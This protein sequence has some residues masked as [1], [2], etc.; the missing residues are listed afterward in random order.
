[1]VVGDLLYV[2]G[3][4]QLRGAD[5]KAAWSDT[6]EVLDLS[7]TNP[8][9]RSIPPPFQRRALAAAAAGGK[10]YALGGLDSVGTS[11]RADTYDPKVGAWIEG[12]KLPPLA[13]YLKGFGVSAF[14]VEE[15]V[16]LSG[17]DGVV[18][19]LDSGTGEWTSGVGRLE[20]PRFFHRLVHQGDRLVFVAGASSSGHLADLESLDLA[21][22]S[23][24]SAAP[25]EA[26]AVELSAWPGFR[27]YGD[28]PT[29]STRLPLKWSEKENI[30]WRVQLPGYGQSA[31][32]V[33]G[34][35][36][37]TTSVEGSNKETLILSSL[38]LD[39]GEVI[40]RRRFPAS[41]KIES[42]EMVSRSAPTPVVDGERLYA[43]WESGD[44]LAVSLEGETLWRRSLTEEYGPF[45][46]NHGVGSSLV[47]TE[48]AVIVQVTHEGPSYFVAVDRATGENR[49]RRELPAKVA[50]TTPTVVRREGRSEVIASGAGRVEG[51]D[52][53]TG[54]LLWSYEGVEK[55]NVPSAVVDGDLVVVA[56]SE[57]GQN[58][59]LRLGG[60]GALNEEQIL[61]RGK[62]VTSGFGSPLIHGDCVLFVNKAGTVSCLDRQSGE[63]RWKQRLAGSC[64]A[65]PIASGEYAYFFSKKGKTV[66]LRPGKDGAEVVAENDL[67]T[68]GVVY[69]VAAT[70]DAILIR[71]GQELVRV[72][73][74]GAMEVHQAST[75][76]ERET[77][78][79]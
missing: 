23:A 46:G 64:W 7:A 58:F 4:W 8:S 53:G 59:A 10:V 65:S 21:G 74:P 34:K 40:W 77:E 61:W 18:Q 32:V 26:D 43:F 52:G 1:V 15:K 48:D 50:W 2:V 54:E 19:V 78:G 41:Q 69:G 70:Q 62:G 42:N 16:F 3:G 31:P 44:L 51:F 37:F 6:M 67:P 9:W 73:K 76:E 66:V 57:P 12:P 30:A 17:G 20:T 14:A 11:R 45:T 29:S 79:R 35:R 55:N 47:L 75:M 60:S 36:V 33:W 24:S 28:G 39:S 38:D 22:L 56:S 25:A 68:D 63:E 13:A 5:E 72:G 71:T 49:W 27:G